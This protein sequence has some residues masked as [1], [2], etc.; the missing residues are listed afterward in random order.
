MRAHQGTCQAC[1]EIDLVEPVEELPE[2][3]NL[4]P[5]C[6]ADFLAEDLNIE[7]GPDYGGSFD[8]VSQV[9]SDADPGL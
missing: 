1:H 5:E 7:P 4:C 3:G 6:Y 8:G 2:V 9:F